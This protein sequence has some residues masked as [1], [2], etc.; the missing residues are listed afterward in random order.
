M[1]R[2][3]ITGIGLVTPLGCGDGMFVYRRLIA[4]QS[5]IR[6]LPENL[7][8]SPSCAVTVAATVPTGSN[9]GDFDESLYKPIERETSKFIR[10]ALHASHL[11]ME[12]AGLTKESLALHYDPRMCGVAIGNG[13]IGSLPEIGAASSSVVTAYKKLSPY[14]VPKILVNMSAGHVSIKYG[15]KGPCHS[16]ATACAAGSHS[17]GD[18]FNFIKLGY[19]DCMLAGGADASIDPV[20]LSGFARMKALSTPP[21]GVFS[22]ADLKSSRPFDIA[23]NGF[24]MGEG[25]G[26]LVLEELSTALKRQAPIIAEIV[27]YGM[28]GDAHHTTSPPSD[29]EGAFNSMATALRVA[30]VSGKEIGYVNTHATS[31]PLGDSVEINAITRLLQNDSLLTQQQQQQQ[32]L[33]ISSTKGA[34]GHLLGAAGA[35]ETAFTA[36][37]L[38][39][40]VVPPT[41]HLD[42]LDPALERP[43]LFKHVPNQA[44]HY[45]DGSVVTNVNNV[46][47]SSSSS[48][49]LPS[50]GG[51]QLKYALKNSFGFGGTNASLLLTKYES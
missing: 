36:L 24:V 19:A 41:L 13:G 30:G 9:E 44:L 22:E 31:T 48:S 2:I 14:F 18:A 10:F 28:S 39:T 23:R 37:A 16:V 25:A 5:G 4:G 29:G 49:S 20:S 7:V 6:K 42:Q 12:N 11:A 8:L 40:N 32:P 21:T 43:G 26:V 46:Q 50:N 51:R 15:L 3:V 33:Y 47:S 1:R 17:I 38:H 34:T 35:V 27:G 45:N